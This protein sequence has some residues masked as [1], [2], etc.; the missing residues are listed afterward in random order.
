MKEETMTDNE[1]YHELKFKS[2][3]VERYSFHIHVQL[4]FL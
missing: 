3:L 2:K 4:S 1:V